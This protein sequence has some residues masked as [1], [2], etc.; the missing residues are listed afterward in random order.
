MYKAKPVSIFPAP[1]PTIVVSPKIL[2]VIFK[3]L[4]ASEIP[5]NESLT[6]TSLGLT[7]PCTLPLLSFQTLPISFHLLLFDAASFTSESVILDIPF[8]S[9]SSCINCSSKQHLPKS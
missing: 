9:I 8:T 6:D 5:Y 7:E 2:E 3:A 4:V 1:S